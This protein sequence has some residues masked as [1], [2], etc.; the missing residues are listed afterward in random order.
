M[1]ALLVR[2]PF[3]CLRGFLILAHVLAL[4]AL[5][6]PSARAQ[7]Y[8]QTQTLAAVPEPPD[9]FGFGVAAGGDTLFANASGGPYYFFTRSGNEW[10]FQHTFSPATGGSR[11]L[12]GDTL[13][14][15]R[16]IYQRTGNE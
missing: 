7:L 8:T 14:L 15:G 6:L 4:L 16:K 10:V 1:N 2:A 13:V 12:D 9:Q 11:D 5:L 3:R